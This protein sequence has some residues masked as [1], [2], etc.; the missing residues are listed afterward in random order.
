[1]YNICRNFS[2]FIVYPYISYKTRNRGS[3]SNARHQWRSGIKGV[4][5]RWVNSDPWVSYS[6][7]GWQVNLTDSKSEIEVAKSYGV[8]D[9]KNE[10]FLNFGLAD[11]KLQEQVDANQP[12]TLQHP[13]EFEVSFKNQSEFIDVRLDNC[14]ASPFKDGEE[15]A[16][17]LLNCSLF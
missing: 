13:L 10:E 4:K 2:V 1:M 17:Q 8:V 7:D 12:L 5:Y 6:H 11:D 9:L 3:K 16:L 15:T 14:W